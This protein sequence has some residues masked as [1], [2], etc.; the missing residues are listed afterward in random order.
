MGGREDFF[1]SLTHT[2]AL[3]FTL[4]KARDGMACICCRLPDLRFIALRYALHR[5]LLRTSWLQKFSFFPFAISSR[6][7]GLA[8]SLRHGYEK[9]IAFVFLLWSLFCLH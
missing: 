3:S 9:V 1:L 2:H 7:N 8:T 4:S 5:R 6:H